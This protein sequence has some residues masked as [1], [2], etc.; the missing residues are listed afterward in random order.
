MDIYS[1]DIDRNCVTFASLFGVFVLSIHRSRTAQRNSKIRMSSPAH[2]QNIEKIDEQN[3][4]DVADG[5]WI[6]F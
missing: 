2:P 1:S 6:S 5:N 4:T 3:K